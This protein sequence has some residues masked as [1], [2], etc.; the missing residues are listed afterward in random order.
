MRT[1]QALI[2]TV[3]S[4]LLQVVLAISGIIVPRFF[5]AL[6]GSSVNGLVSS[7]T[8]FISYINLVEAGISAAGMV[9]L[10]GPLAR[11]EK[12]NING[13]FAAANRFYRQSGLIFA[14]LIGL[15]VLLYP[16]AVK[17]EIG[18]TAF[19]R[20]MIAVLSIS[21]IV[22]YFI[23]G[24][25][26][27]LLTADQRGYV[28]AIAQIFGTVI[29]TVAS[30]ILMELKFSALL[31]KGAAAVIYI[32]RS[33][34]VVVYAKR[35]YKWLTVKEKPNLAAFEQR[36][37]VLAHQIA[38]MVISNSAMILLTF[39]LKENALVEVSV[40]SVYNLVAYSLTL[41]LSSVQTG[42]GA[43]FGQVISNGEK[44]VL[45]KSFKTYEFIFFLVIF[46]AYSCMAVLLHPFITLYSADFEDGGIYAR[47]IVIA[48]FTVWG[49]LQSVR[50]PAVT[51]ITAAG[52]YKKTQTRAIIEAVI[53]LTVSLV[54][55]R[56]LGIVGVV[57]GAICSSLYRTTDI[58]YCER[59]LI[60][61]T[62]GRT[63]RRIGVNLL[64]SAVLIFAGLQLVPTVTNSWLV[65][66]A[67]AVIFGISAAAV[68]CG[69]NTLI[70]PDEFKQIIY[71]AKGVF[72]R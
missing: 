29:M 69:V 37:A 10:Y 38:G 62:I 58:L 59:H 6:Y 28:I 2:N 70:E 57:T 47:P 20:T 72:K 43:G 4:I 33:I 42:I 34:V 32:L 12:D 5:T 67:S 48:L 51:I 15:L 1:R 19:I 52:H 71:R 14:A 7:I 64:L 22:D 18:D 45:N 56:P 36:W 8:Q 26:R 39:F 50:A 46:T 44:E 25:Y 35:R 66:L 49:F 41:V 40:Y 9:A 63:L 60:R 3:T 68:I 54:L 53:N 65:W 61:G 24:K 17:N 31:V 11:G 21:G 55:V 30:I 23:L 27:M 13:V 16:F